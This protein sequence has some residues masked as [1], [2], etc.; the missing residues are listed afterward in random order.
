MD[1]GALGDLPAV[2]KIAPVLPHQFP[3]IGVYID[4]RVHTGFRY[5]VKPLNVSCQVANI[6]FLVFQ[7]SLYHTFYLLLFSKDFSFFFLFTIMFPI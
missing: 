1:A 5:K 3:V 2:Y 4:P 6:S 7:Y